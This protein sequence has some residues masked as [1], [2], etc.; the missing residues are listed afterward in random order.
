MFFL[1]VLASVAYQYYQVASP[2]VA[3]AG[4]NNIPQNPYVQAP[5]QAVYEMVPTGQ[6]ES[7]VSEEYA[8]NAEV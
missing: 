8:K 6:V 4:D 7:G 5:Q 3:P 2:P 1:I